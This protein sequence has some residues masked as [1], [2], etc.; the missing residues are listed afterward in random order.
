MLYLQNHLEHDTILKRKLHETHRDKKE[1][2]RIGMKIQVT[3]KEK[4]YLLHN[5]NH[6]DNHNNTTQLHRDNNNNRKK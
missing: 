6:K 4:W 2:L 3:T 5:N 1:F